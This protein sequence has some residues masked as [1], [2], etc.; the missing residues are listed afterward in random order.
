MESTIIEKL[1]DG[2][3]LVRLEKSFYE[4]P[5]VF[6]AS[7]KFTGQCIINVQSVDETHV[8]VFFESETLP[9]EELLG[10]AK[11]F[12]NEV[13]DQQHRVDLNKKFGYLRDLI[14]EHA[15]SPIVNLKERL[16]G[17]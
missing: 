8:G 10:V 3:M 15:F 6:A 17:K 5:A 12:C 2:G 7:Y 1:E 13:L 14:V 16:D 9:E 11:R 4:K